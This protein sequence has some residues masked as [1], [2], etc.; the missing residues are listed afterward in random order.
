MADIE[1]GHLSAALIHMGTTDRQ[2]PSTRGHLLSF[3]T[4][5]KSDLPRQP[6]R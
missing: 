5:V 3:L 1:E 4:A 6:G 2:V